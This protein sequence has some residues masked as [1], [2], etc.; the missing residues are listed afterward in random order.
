MMLVKGTI[1][2]NMSV[3]R[4]SQILL[5]V[6]AA[7]HCGCHSPKKLK[8][9]SSIEGAAS[10][11]VG[12]ELA[13]YLNSNGWQMETFPYEGTAGIHQLEPLLQRRCDLSF[14]LNDNTADLQTDDLRTVLPFYPNVSYIFYRSSINPQNLKDLLKNHKVALSEDDQTFYQ[15]LFE[16]YGVHTD[17][18]Q[19]NSFK[20][21]NS[22]MDALDQLDKNETEVLCVFAAIHNPYVQEM[23][24]RGWDVFSLGDIKYANMGS[25]VEGF[26]MRTLGAQPFIVPRNFFGEKPTTPIYT[27]ALNEVLVTHKDANPTVI[28]DLVRSIFNGKQQLSKQNILFNYVK[29]D[30]DKNALNFPLHQSTIDYLNRDMPSFFERYAEVFGV[31]FSFLVVA[32]GGLTGIRKIRKERID[33]YY[34]RGVSCQSILEV[35][36]ISNEAVQQL[37]NEKLTADESFTILLN[38]VEKRRAEIQESAIVSRGTTKS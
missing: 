15:G 12:K 19:F 5:F 1:S 38:L 31:V 27:I 2:D 33:K 21:R 6:I 13:G 22:V 14:C 18:I 32:L 25:S 30:F 34:R 8:L 26:C 35:E 36:K 28:Y 37:Q 20:I 7:T 17:S 29:E 9:A 11:E 16:Y 23:L 10:T 4:L 3:I 24:D